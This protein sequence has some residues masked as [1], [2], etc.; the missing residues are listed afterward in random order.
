VE[1]QGVA[2]ASHTLT[3]PFMGIAKFLINYYEIPP[4]R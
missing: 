4:D 2:F 1:P 3:A